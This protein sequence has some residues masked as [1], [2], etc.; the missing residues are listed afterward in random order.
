MEGLF[1]IFLCLYTLFGIFIGFDGEYPP[2]D[3]NPSKWKL[4]ITLNKLSHSSIVIISGMGLVVF[5]SWVFLVIIFLDVFLSDINIPM[6][7]KEI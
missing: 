5:G 3:Y 2:K 6:Y 4:L 1:V 7:R